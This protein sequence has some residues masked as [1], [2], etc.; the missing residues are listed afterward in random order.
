MKIVCGC[1]NEV[2]LDTV[3]G[4]TGQQTETDEERGQYAR[5][6]ISKLRFWQEHDVVGLS[7]EKCEKGIWLFT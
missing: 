2:E 7:C 5:V 1:G 3:D 4:D 6:D